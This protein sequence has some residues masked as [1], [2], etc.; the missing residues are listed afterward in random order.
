MVSDLTSFEDTHACSR[1]GGML[2]APSWP[3]KDWFVSL[4]QRCTCRQPFPPGL[5]FFPVHLTRPCYPRQR[6]KVEMYI[7]KGNAL[8]QA[9]I[10]S[11]Q[12]C[13]AWNPCRELG[14]CQ[15]GICLFYVIFVWK[16]G[17]FRTFTAST[18]SFLTQKTLAL[19]LLVTGRRISEIAALS[20]VF[21]I[22]LLQLFLIGY[23]VSQP[24][25][26]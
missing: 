18:F 21:Q 9:A 3:T 4:N 5:S 2:I 13:S 17:L 1:S 26:A 25:T 8:P 6:K 12:V 20:Q 24:G 11:C 22:H 16:K 23:Q 10:F 7:G 19:I 15:F 14:L